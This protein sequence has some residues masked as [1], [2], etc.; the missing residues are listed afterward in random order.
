M[1]LNVRFTVDSQYVCLAYFGREATLNSS[2]RLI[3]WQAKQ[4][5]LPFS[6]L[7]L[8]YRMLFLQCCS[9]RHHNNPVPA[10]QENVNSLIR[11]LMQLVWPG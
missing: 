9:M 2:V 5:L 10:K 3:L 4:F 7:D 11:L 6:V 1:P 8:I